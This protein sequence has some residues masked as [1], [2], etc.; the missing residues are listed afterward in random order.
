MTGKKGKARAKKATVLIC[1]EC[2]SG[3][4]VVHF[5][6]KVEIPCKNRPLTN[7]IKATWEKVE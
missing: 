2:N 5:N 7:C 1:R 3:F 6:R 4:C